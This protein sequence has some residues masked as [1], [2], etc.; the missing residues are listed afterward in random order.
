[1]AY[2][3]RVDT[4]LM[5]RKTYDAA[6]ALGSGAY[7]GVTNYVF[8]RTL[9]E[10]P[11]PGVQLVSANA[12][13]LVASLKRQPGGEICVM[14]GGDFARTLFAAD[15]VDEVGVNIQPILLGAGIPLFQQLPSAIPLELIRTETLAGGCVYALYS[16]RR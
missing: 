6:K 1:A 12:A 16:V 10:S 15:L 2:W 5:G 4:V 7:P 14:G 11:E 13:E 8:S 3:A 9:R